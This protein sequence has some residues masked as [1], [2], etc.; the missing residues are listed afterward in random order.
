MSLTSIVCKVLESFVR[1]E[2]VKFMEENNLFTKCQY[3]FRNKRSCVTQLL[4]VLNDFT[5]LADQPASCTKL[6]IESGVHQRICENNVIRKW[7]I[8]F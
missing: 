8:I 5:Y 7:Q 3:G 6:D 4:E 1:D 2:V